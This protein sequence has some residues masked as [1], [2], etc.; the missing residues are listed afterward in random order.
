VSGVGVPLELR[1]QDTTAAH[2]IRGG[3]LATARPTPVRSDD[4]ARKLIDGCR[5][6]G[7]LTIEVWVKLTYAVLAEPK[8]LMAGAIVMLGNLKEQ[9]SLMLAQIGGNYRAGLGPV[10]L[11]ALRQGN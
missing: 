4:P 2:W 6:S 7:A 3:G 9:R 11:A 8:D 5:A 10:P 1:I